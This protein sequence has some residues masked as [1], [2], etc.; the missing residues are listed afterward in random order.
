MRTKWIEGVGW[1]SECRTVVPNDWKGANLCWGV[2]AKGKV[3]TKV[4]RV[5]MHLHGRLSL[6]MPGSQRLGCIVC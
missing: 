2:G 5:G 6:C 1:G 4:E 3:V